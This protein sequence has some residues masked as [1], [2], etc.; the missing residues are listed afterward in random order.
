ML[1]PA[2]ARCVCAKSAKPRSFIGHG[3]SSGRCKIMLKDTV[4]VVSCLRSCDKLP[5]WFRF[6]VYVCM[7]KKCILCGW[8]EVCTEELSH[9]ESF[10]AKAQK[11]RHVHVTDKQLWP[12]GRWRCAAVCFLKMSSPC[13]ELM[14]AAL[15]WRETCVTLDHNVS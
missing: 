5:A 6:Y 14:L 12:G 1:L 10:L 13:S 8:V 7:Y 11:H 9:P 4:L 3:F 15:P 2:Y